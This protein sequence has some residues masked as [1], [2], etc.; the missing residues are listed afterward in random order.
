MRLNKHIKLLFT[1]LFLSAFLQAQYLPRQGESVHFSYGYAMLLKAPEG[2]KQAYS[3]AWQLQ[4]LNEI[5]LGSKNH[6]SLGY[7]LGF[8]QFNWRSNLRITTS[9]GADQLNYSF[10][11]ADST[12]NKNRL[13]A[14]YVD[15]PFE[16]RWRSNVNKYGRYW[17]FY[18][19]GLVGYRINSSSLFKVDNYSVKNYG[20]T[21]LATVHYGAFARTGFWMFN[22]YAYY[23]INP[24]FKRTAPGWENLKN[25][26]SLTLGLSLSI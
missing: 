8:S 26:H 6:I 17:R 9:P 10:L 16:V 25:M 7:G 3:D 14:T 4:F 15:L 18:V 1:A 5:L 13:L 20:I 21:D 23:G 2:L 11:A 22:L 24:V 12:Y 19:G